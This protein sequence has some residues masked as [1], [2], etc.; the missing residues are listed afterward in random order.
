MDKMN[1][2][3]W[4]QVDEVNDVFRDEYDIPYMVNILKLIHTMFTL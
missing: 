4:G 1:A 3:L 2:I